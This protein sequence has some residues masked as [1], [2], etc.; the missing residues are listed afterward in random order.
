VLSQEEKERMM[1]CTRRV[2]GFTY[3]YFWEGAKLTLNQSPYSNENALTRGTHLWH[4]RPVS[5]EMFRNFFDSEA[6]SMTKV[7]TS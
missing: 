6:F 5:T 7:G 3:V 4:H 2:T 1:I